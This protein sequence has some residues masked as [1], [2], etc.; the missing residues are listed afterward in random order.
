MNPVDTTNPELRTS[1]CIQYAGAMT[2]WQ[3]LRAKNPN[4][5]LA[6]FDALIDKA[7]STR[8]HLGFSWDHDA[9]LAML[10]H[11]QQDP[12]EVDPFIRDFLLNLDLDDSRFTAVTRLT[13]DGD[14]WPYLVIGGFREDGGEFEFS[15]LEGIELFTEVRRLSLGMSAQASL[16]PL[17]ALT[18]LESLT[19][20]ADELIDSEALLELP[21][22]ETIEVLN[23]SPAERQF[24]NKVDVLC[25]LATKGVRV[26]GVA[27]A[28]EA[29]VKEGRHH[30]AMK[31]YEHLLTD[32]SRSSP[33]LLEWAA[34]A[35]AMSGQR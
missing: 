12:D 28:A 21:A 24:A 23:L 25:E 20:T 7:T 10:G 5:L 13:L 35:K 11:E 16:E 2:A 29:L 6:T 18:K 15:S 30:D 33:R 31:L 4:L 27:D 22:L 3:T 26:F 9:L 32:A 34:K 19:L 14:Q 8:L 17:V 1:L